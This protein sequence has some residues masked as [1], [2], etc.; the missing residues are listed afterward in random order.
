MVVEILRNFV[1]AHSIEHHIG[2][3]VY[4]LRGDFIK[5]KSVLGMRIL[6]PAISGER[7]YVLAVASLHVKHF[8]NLL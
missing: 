7:A 3:V 8:P 2:H 5:Y 1:Q 4:D 6:Q